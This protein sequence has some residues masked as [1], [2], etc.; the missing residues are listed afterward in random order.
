MYDGRT[1]T[2]YLIP[3]TTLIN[4]STKHTTLRIIVT[5][6]DEKYLIPNTILE[7]MFN[8]YMI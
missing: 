6:V 5:K 8:N 7:T 2:Y 4:V 3:N 1:N